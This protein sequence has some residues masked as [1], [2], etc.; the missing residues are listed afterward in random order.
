MLDLEADLILQGQWT[1]KDT[2]AVHLLAYCMRLL[3]DK[4]SMSVGSFH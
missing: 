2:D 3:S 4:L 1:V